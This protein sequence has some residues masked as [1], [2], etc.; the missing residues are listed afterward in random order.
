MVKTV[1]RE[2]LLSSAGVVAGP[3]DAVLDR[4]P[5]S[6][7]AFGPL[8][9]PVL[10][11]GRATWEPAWSRAVPLVVD[12]LTGSSA[13]RRSQWEKAL[14]ADAPAGLGEADVTTQFLLSAS[15]WPGRS[16]PPASRPVWPAQP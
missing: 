15:R 1:G 16:R 9:G 12:T 2:A 8:P 13:E 14:G 10:L 4:A 3:I 7:R 5:S 11:H 6:V